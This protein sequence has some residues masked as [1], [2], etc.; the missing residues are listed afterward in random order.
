MAGEGNATQYASD[1]TF[2]Q[3]MDWTIKKDKTKCELTIL[4]QP[5]PKD[6]KSLSSLFCIV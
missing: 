3:L 1:F 4:K 6:G 2:Q 5:Y